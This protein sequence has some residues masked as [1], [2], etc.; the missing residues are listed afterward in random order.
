L[1]TLQSNLSFASNFEIEEKNLEEQAVVISTIH[2]VKGMQYPVVIIPDVVERKMPTIYQKDK[3]A[4]P[5]EL[6]KGVQSEFDEKELHLQEERRLFYVAITRAK[7][8]TNN[9]LC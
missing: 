2:G 1:K 7:R 5:L 3:F 9:Y 8:Q 4:I 6:L